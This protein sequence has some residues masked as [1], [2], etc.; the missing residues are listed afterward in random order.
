MIHIF[1]EIG[2]PPSP[3]QFEEVIGTISTQLQ[4]VNQRSREEGIS[5]LMDEHQKRSHV[6]K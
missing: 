3:N 5:F 2:E 1:A 6:S 4:I